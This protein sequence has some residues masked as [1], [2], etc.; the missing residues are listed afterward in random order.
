[1]LLS[2]AVNRRRASLPGTMT[3]APMGSLPS[4][5]LTVTGPRVST[6]ATRNLKVPHLAF[7]VT[8]TACVGADGESSAECVRAQDDSRGGGDNVGE[9]V[10]LSSVSGE[11]A[12]AT[13]AALKSAQTAEQRTY[14]A[15]G[16]LAEIKE[17]VQA[18]VMWLTVF[19]PY[20]TGL[21]LTISRGSMGG[22]NTQVSNTSPHVCARAYAL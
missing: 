5:T 2:C 7:A 16:E 3:V 6:F 21:L 14:S 19:V 8:P 12:A 22:G 10:V 17:A 11:T 9:V 4:T 15:Y 1:M 18:S 13:L 20:S